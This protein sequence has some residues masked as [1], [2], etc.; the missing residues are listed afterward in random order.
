MK[1]LVACEESQRVC[2]AFRD[3]GFDAYSCDI[4]PCTG[5][6]PEWHFQCDALE[7]LNKSW[8]LIIAHPPCTYLSNAGIHYCHEKYGDA[9]IERRKKLYDAFE[10]FMQFITAD[11]KHIAV[12]NP[13]GIVSTLYR[14]PDQYI[15]PYMFG[16][17]VAKKTGLWLKNLPLLQPTNI[18][19][20]EWYV[21]PD[22]RRESKFHHDFCK[23]RDNAERS[24]A[25]SKT[26]PCI[27]EAMAQ[28]WGNY[29]R[30][31]QQ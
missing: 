4:Q 18:V 25:R 9:A 1:V 27:A 3:R 15:Q 2:I 31:E 29:L 28:Q 21:Y 12:E 10:F 13:V 17:P 14:K 7:L 16:Y 23:I 5:G 24:K 8:D 20:P 22:G 30:G 26:F 11:C 6:H 19:K